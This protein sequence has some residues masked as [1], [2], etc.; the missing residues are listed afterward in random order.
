MAFDF[1]QFREWYY[2]MKAED[3][4]KAEQ[5]GAHVKEADHVHHHKWVANRIEFRKKLFRRILWGLIAAIFT[6]AAGVYVTHYQEKRHEAHGQG[7][8]IHGEPNIDNPDTGN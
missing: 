1:N 8:H 4:E 7:P 6:V 2:K 5:R 3:I